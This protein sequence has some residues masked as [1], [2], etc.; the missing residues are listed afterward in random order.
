MSYYDNTKNR[1][2]PENRF[3]GDIEDGKR[4]PFGCYSKEEA[5][6]KFA[7][8]TD[9][10][11]L[12]ADVTVIKGQIIDILRRLDAL[13]YKAINIQSFVASPAT[14]E[15]GSNATVNLTWSLNKEAITQTINGSAVQGT[16][17]QVTGISETTSFRL[18]VS[19]GDTQATKTAIVTAA[20]QIYY[21]AAAD[22]S[23]VTSLTK[24]LS[25]NKK[26]TITVNA[27]AGQYIIYAYPARLGNVSFWVDNFE[28]GFEPAVEQSITNESGYTETYKLYRSTNANLGET[29][30]EIKEG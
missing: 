22:F 28:G 6:A 24:V 29:T 3:I 12:T 5:D 15:R 30:V 27:G 20:N 18:E 7:L 9:L 23:I 17:M 2:N 11:I 13:E 4:Y 10:D 26:R 25:D 16:S 1:F 21:G 19:D 8:K 14:I